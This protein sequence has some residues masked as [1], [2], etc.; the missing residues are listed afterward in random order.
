MAHANGWID[1]QCMHMLTT[2]SRNAKAKTVGLG[3]VLVLGVMQNHTY[4]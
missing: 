2:A 3:S 4:E 1:T